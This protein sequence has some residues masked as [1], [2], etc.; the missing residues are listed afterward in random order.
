MCGR[1]LVVVRRENGYVV[2]ETVVSSIDTGAHV[3]GR[4]VFD[5]VRPS[6]ESKCKRETGEDVREGEME[7][8][9]EEE[10]QAKRGMLRRN[11]G[12]ETEG[13]MWQKKE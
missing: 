8:E 13:S 6:R 12:G 10:R 7:E 3:A 5:S 2:I 1:R 11:G 9:G 4:G